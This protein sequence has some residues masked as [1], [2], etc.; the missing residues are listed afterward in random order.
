M[1]Y[2]PVTAKG[3]SAIMRARVGRDGDLALVLGAVARDPPRH[4][5]AAIGDEVLQQA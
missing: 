2:A 1:A 3:M 5:L 4:Q